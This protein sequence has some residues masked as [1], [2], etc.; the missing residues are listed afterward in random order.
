MVPKYILLIAS[1]ILVLTTPHQASAEAPP[2]AEMTAFIF[3]MSDR[4]RDGY[5]SWDEVKAVDSSIIRSE[6]DMLDLNNDGLISFQ[7]YSA[8]TRT[9]K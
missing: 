2:S 9:L 4:N 3:G 8:H 7:E 6:F 1:L 5:M